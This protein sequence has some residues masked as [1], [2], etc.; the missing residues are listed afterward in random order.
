[1]Y[2]YFKNKDL[3]GYD[4][5]G[6][7]LPKQEFNYDLKGFTAGGAIIKNKLF[8]FVNGEKE[9]RT[10]PGTLWTASTPTSPANGITVSQAQKADLDALQQFLITKYNYNPGAYEGYS[11]GSK[12]Q[13]LSTKIDWNINDKNTFTL[14]YNYLR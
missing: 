8:F 11:Y 6:V 13:R 1:M 10:E 4:V 14:K 2:E 7:T 5:N 3:Q 12:S 9:E